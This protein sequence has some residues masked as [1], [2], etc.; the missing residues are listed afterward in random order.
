MSQQLPDEG[1]KQLEANPVGTSPKTEPTTP[2]KSVVAILAANANESSLYQPWLNHPPADI[3]VRIVPDFEVRQSLPADVDLVVTHNHY[4]WDELAVLRQAMTAGDRGVLVLSDGILEFRNS[5]QNYNIPAGSLLQPALAHKIATIGPAQSRWLESWGNHGCCETVG[6][7]RL[8]TAAAANGW[9]AVPASRSAGE[10]TGSA[11][12]TLTAP[13][14]PTHDTAQPA[15][16]LICSARTPAFSEAQWAVTLAQFRALSDYLQSHPPQHQ[17]QPVSVRW[18]V[19]ERIAAELNLPA[20]SLSDG[21]ITAAL[22]L[23]SAVITMPST[24]QLEAMLYRRPVAT[25]DFFQVPNYVP[26]AWQITA[27][28]HFG[29]IIPQL[30]EPCPLRQ[31]Y[32]DSLLRDQLWYHSSASERMWTLIANM[33]RIAKRQRQQ[34]IPIRFPRHILPPESSDLDHDCLTGSEIDWPRLQPLREAW[35]QQARA[36]KVDVWELTEVAAAYQRAQQYSEERGMLHRLVETH[37]QTVQTYE[38]N[39]SQTQQYM[40]FLQENANELQSRWEDTKRRLEQRNTEFAE[41][42]Q[43]VLQLAAEKKATHEKLQEAYADAKRKQDRVNELRTH[44]QEIRVAY[45]ALKNQQAS[46]QPT[47]PPPLLT[48]A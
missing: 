29:S 7:P 19:A 1:I 42:Q 30:F 4:R 17:G 22:E 24:V 46:A 27:A 47:R 2:R 8:D 18:R 44:Y 10:S 15:C 32:Q 40:T 28:E 11:H 43:R 36:A 20:E 3:D 6:L 34:G 41:T 14:Q 31:F 37:R 21:P 26:A 33:A 48:E 39:I 9:H 23:A 45:E 35:R 16:L 25:L 13:H 38:Y 5:W 12:L